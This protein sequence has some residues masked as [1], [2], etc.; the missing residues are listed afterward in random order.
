MQ[1][2]QVGIQTNPN[3]KLVSKTVDGMITMG[4]VH[5]DNVTSGVMMRVGNPSPTTPHFMNMDKDGDAGTKGRRGTQFVCPGS[6]QVDA[7]HSVGEEIPGIMLDANTGDIVIRTKG[8]LRIQANDIDIN[9]QGVK[10]EEGKEHGIINVESTAAINLFSKNITTLAS[11]ENRVE[12]GNAVHIRGISI[13]DMF[14]GAIEMLDASSSFK[15]STG[16]IPVPWTP[17][18][19]QEAVLKRKRVG[20]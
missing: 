4:E 16:H 18:E 7:G 3:Y 13:L 19:F 15:G 5:G 10:D 11:N 12:S 8:R 20:S 14:G 1:N 6:F 2:Q 9:V 17:R